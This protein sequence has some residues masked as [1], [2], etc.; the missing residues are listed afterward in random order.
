MVSDNPEKAFELALRSLA[1]GPGWDS[2]YWVLIAI[3]ARLGREEEGKAYAAELLGKHLTVT[4]ARYEHVLPIR[5]AS[6]M[7]LVLDSL[8][9]AGIPS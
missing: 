5:N 8:R 9:Q 2:T 4:T 7:K 3:C 6:S 1:L